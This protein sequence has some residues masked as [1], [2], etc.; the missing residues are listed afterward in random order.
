MSFSSP[1]R[2]EIGL[3]RDCLFCDPKSLKQ[4]RLLDAGD[5]MSSTGVPSMKDGKLTVDAAYLGY[6]TNPEVLSGGAQTLFPNIIMAATE[7]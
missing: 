4:A 7:A 6:F 2:W 5:N 1:Q 3:I